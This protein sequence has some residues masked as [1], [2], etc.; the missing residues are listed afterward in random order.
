M[1]FGQRSLAQDSNVNYI[2]V[3]FRILADRNDPAGLKWIQGDKMYYVFLSETR[4]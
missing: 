2:E 4:T 3:P 1:G